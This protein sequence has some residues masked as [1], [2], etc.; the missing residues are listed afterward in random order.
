MVYFVAKAHYSWSFVDDIVVALL[1]ESLYILWPER[2]KHQNDLSKLQTLWA[3][4]AMPLL[5]SNKQSSDLN[6]IEILCAD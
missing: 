3:F 5:Q 6:H 2:V 4:F 1:I